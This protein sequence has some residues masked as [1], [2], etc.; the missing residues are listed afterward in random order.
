MG[1]KSVH[2]R[3]VLNDTQVSLGKATR[4]VEVKWNVSG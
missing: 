1:E 3:I 4:C 2:K